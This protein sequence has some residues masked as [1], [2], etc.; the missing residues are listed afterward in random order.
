VAEKFH[1]LGKIV[2]IFTKFRTLVAQGPAHAEIGQA[3]IV[4]QNGQLLMQVSK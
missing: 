2:K 4:N 3:T 1:K